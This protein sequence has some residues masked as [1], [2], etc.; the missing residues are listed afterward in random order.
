MGL[1]INTIQAQKPKRSPTKEPAHKR[2]DLN[3]EINL[4]IFS[5][6]FKDK[7]KESFFSEM[8]ILLSSGLDINAAFKVVIDEE[9]KDQEKKIIEQIYNSLVKGDSIYEAVEKSGKF[10]EYDYFC[11]K[12]GEESGRLSEVLFELGAF[13]SRKIK[14]KRKFVNALTYPMIVL[15]T[16]IGS[17][18]FMLNFLV[19]MFVDVFNRTNSELPAL[20]R[21]IISLSKATSERMPL[22]MLVIMGMVLLYYLYRKKVSFRRGSSELIIRIPILGELVKLFYME[23]FVISMVLLTK[24]R[25]SIVKAL[26]LIKNIIGFYP[27][28]TAIHK[29]ENDIVHGKLLHESMAQFAIFD[30]RIVSMV[31]VGEEVNQLGQI[32]EKMGVKFSEELEYRINNV[33]NLLEPVLIIFI[34]IIVGVILISMYLPIF[35][36]GNTIT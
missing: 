24:S 36:I 9:S 20:T 26:G 16:A 2:F 11:L 33:N 28:E 21:F 7:K 30:K 6:K 15:F 1:N 4:S 19:P 3:R 8:G 29:I 18:V 17:V 10:S 23:R 34:G 32:F 31:K 27:L 13:Y 14:Y 35:Q 5:S 12:I 22:L 25:V